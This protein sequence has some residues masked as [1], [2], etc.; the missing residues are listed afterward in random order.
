L[1]RKVVRV[2]FVAVFGNLERR[3]THS[4]AW[5]IRGGK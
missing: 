4:K 2:S 5:A 1:S 3:L